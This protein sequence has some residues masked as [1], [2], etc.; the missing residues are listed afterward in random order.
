MRD[1]S[2]PGKDDTRSRWIEEGSIRT[3][4]S[5]VGESS[6]MK[7]QLGSLKRTV[8]SKQ[9]MHEI[10]KV[11]KKLYRKNCQTLPTSLP[12]THGISPIGCDFNI[13]GRNAIYIFYFH[14]KGF[15]C[16]LK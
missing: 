6:W 1:T 15:L 11:M 2:F 16:Y 12:S 10:C 3:A 4:T 8:R 14:Q 9:D 7:N 13:K 5:A